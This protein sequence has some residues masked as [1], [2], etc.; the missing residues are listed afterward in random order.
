MPNDV[1]LL[2]Q[3]LDWVPDEK[4]RNMIFVDNPAEIFGFPPVKT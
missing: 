1:D 2:D 3:M 4:V